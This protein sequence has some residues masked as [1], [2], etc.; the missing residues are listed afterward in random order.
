MRDFPDNLGVLGAAAQ[1]LA[2]LVALNHSGHQRAARAGG[3]A[4]AVL[5]L[6]SQLNRT[7]AGSSRRRRPAFPAV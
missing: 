6:I 2:N 7:G 1:A 3:G 4:E 5:G